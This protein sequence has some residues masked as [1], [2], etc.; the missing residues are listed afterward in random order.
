MSYFTLQIP[1]KEGIVGERR[2][3]DRVEDRV[4]LRIILLIYMV[5]GVGGGLKTKVLCV[6]VH[7]VHFYPSNEC[8]VKRHSFFPH[9][10][11][12]YCVCVCVCVFYFFHTHQRLKPK[13]F[14]SF[15]MGGDIICKRDK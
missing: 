4:T 7:F 5:C 13:P 3:K 2:P 14:F 9:L 8:Y 6:K 12:V 1:L 11:C 15:G 10:V